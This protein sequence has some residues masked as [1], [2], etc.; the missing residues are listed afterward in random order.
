MYCFTL[1]YMCTEYLLGPI[2]CKSIFFFVIFFISQMKAALSGLSEDVQEQLMECVSIRREDLGKALIGN[3]ASISQSHLT[4]FDWKLKV[5][6]SSSL[7]PCYKYI[8]Q[9]SYMSVIT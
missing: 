1:L 2:N 4:D 7:H 5:S 9:K 6:L 3:T 8:L